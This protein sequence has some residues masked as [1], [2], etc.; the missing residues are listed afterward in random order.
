MRTR[1][2][3]LLDGLDGMRTVAQIGEIEPALHMEYLCGYI[4]TLVFKQR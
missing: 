2:R 3:K 4:F 1:C